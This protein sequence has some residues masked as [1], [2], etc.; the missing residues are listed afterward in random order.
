MVKN[1]PANVG[2]AKRHGFDPWVGKIPR[3]RNGG[4]LQCPCLE[5]PMNRAAWWAIVH[6]VTMCQTQLSMQAISR[7]A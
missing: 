3:E 7:L 5:N 6:G 4:P 2:D 1:L